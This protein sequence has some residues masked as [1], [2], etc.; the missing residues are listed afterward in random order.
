MGC[1]QNRKLSKSSARRTRTKEK[2]N[3]DIF[4]SSSN[5]SENFKNKCISPVTQLECKSER[6]I[7]SGTK[8]KQ[9]KENNVFLS[10]K[11]RDL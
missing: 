10:E 5:S 3:Q 1:L 8:T 11:M 7:K 2:L 9:K 4:S 6:R